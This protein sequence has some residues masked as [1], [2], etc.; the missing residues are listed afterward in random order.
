MFRPAA[1][2]VLVLDLHAHRVGDI[3]SFAGF[4]TS[5]TSSPAAGS[6]IATA[7]EHLV[8]LLAF[9]SNEMRQVGRARLRGPER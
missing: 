3:G 2:A 8:G 5:F 6:T 7:L 9:G 4:I 1:V